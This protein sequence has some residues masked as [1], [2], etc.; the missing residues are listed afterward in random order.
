MHR[1]KYYNTCIYTND[2]RLKGKKNN[3]NKVKNELVLFVP[4]V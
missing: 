2:T 4:Y 3:K 1:Y